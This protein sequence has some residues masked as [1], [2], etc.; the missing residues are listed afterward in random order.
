MSIPPRD[1]SD[2][3]LAA[4]IGRLLA[5]TDDA[6]WGDDNLTAAGWQELHA[7]Q[8]ELERRLRPMALTTLTESPEPAVVQCGLCLRVVA[9]LA[10]GR[11]I[12]ADCAAFP[13]D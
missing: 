2:A 6:E 12:C 8:G 13:L 10:P 4:A 1:L 11:S 9:A 5:V 3:D 7:L